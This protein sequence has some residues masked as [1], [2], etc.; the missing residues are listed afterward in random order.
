METHSRCFQFMNDM[1]IISYDIS[2]TK[3]RTRFS[4]YIKKFGHRLQYSV[5]EIDNS[6]KILY[7]IIT[8]IN[9]KF[10][11]TF[12]QTDS[13]YIFHMSSTCKIEKF[14]YAKNEDDTLFIV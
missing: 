7:N 8:D 11:K 3:K 9:N 1:V 12:D 6:E 14:G 2:D 5:Y 4:K 13:V 10:S